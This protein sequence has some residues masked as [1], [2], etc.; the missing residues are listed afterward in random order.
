MAIGAAAKLASA[1]AKTKAGQHF[2]RLLTGKILK[3]RNKAARDAQMR[4][5]GGTVPKGKPKNAVTS[6]SQAGRRALAEA[7]SASG[8]PSA[9]R[10]IGE[11]QRGARGARNV[12]ATRG[13]VP[14]TRKDQP[15]AKVGAKK[16]PATTGPR[17]TQTPATQARKNRRDP[18]TID[19]LPSG[20]KRAFNTLPPRA[21]ETVRANLRK[22]QSV[23]G[24]IATIGSL[25]EGLSGST[26]RQ[27][28][29]PRPKPRPEREGR[30]RV[31]D[32]PQRPEPKGP[33]DQARRPITAEKEMESAI[34]EGRMRPV[35]ATPRRPEFGLDTLADRDK[36]KRFMKDRFGINV[37]Y[38]DE[39][40]AMEDRGEGPSRAKGGFVTRR[41][42]MYKK[43]AK[44]KAK[45]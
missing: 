9:G 35:R 30:R 8:S 27:A 1:A 12:P 22:G 6:T 37:T 19:Q 7:R 32:V 21:K 42:G 13:K 26:P 16:V 41:G 36:M 5:V 43:P 23:A 34:R 14:A 17:G 40:Q 33:R 3:Y 20:A 29:P 4:K 45:R 44:K 38:D 11:A 25:L 28:T 24:A 31:I 18:I 2:L 15:P 39:Q 10:A